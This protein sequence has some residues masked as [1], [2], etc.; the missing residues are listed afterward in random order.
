MST[1]VPVSPFMPHDD[2]G[3]VDDDEDDDDV[4]D[5][6]E[7]EEEEA[8]EER[9]EDEGPLV[10]GLALALALLPLLVVVD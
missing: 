8:E 6:D 3:G 2:D 9:E 5:F 10:D 7:E 1:T 4:D